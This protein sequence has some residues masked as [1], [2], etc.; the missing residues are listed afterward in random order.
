MNVF[1]LLVP[2][3]DELDTFS[4]F[5]EI[6]QYSIPFRI[7]IEKGNLQNSK[8]QSSSELVEL[9]DGIGGIDLLY[10]RLKNSNSLSNFFLELKDLIER[11]IKYQKSNTNALLKTPVSSYKLSTR[12][13]SDLDGLWDNIEWVH[14]SLTSIHI[15]FHDGN[16]RKHVV[17]INLPDNYP[18]E[19]PLCNVAFPRVVEFN[20]DPNI[21]TLST[22]INQIQEQSDRYQDLWEQLE[23]FDEN[24]CVLEPEHPTYSSCFRRIAIDK[25]SSLQIEIDPI[26]P[27]QSVPECRFLGADRTILPLKTKY[28]KNFKLW[29]KNHCIRENLETILEISFISKKDKDTSNFNWQQEMCCAIC[30]SYRMNNDVPDRICD[31][32]NCSKGFHTFCLSEWLK[33]LPN[34]QQSYDTIFGD[35]PYCSYQISVKIQTTT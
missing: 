21:D 4:G 1:P 31:N 9:L 16:N 13:I 33:T 15:S 14:P 5:I 10:S 29:K 11:A 17:E 28:R 22:V 19:P 25:H 6:E 3:N 23:D 8:I 2:E 30:Y 35:C 26:D 24:C 12:L 32:V 18:I 27:C 20:W 7:E 34:C